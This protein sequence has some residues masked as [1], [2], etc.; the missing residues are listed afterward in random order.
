M[1]KLTKRD[2]MLLKKLQKANLYPGLQR[3]LEDNLRRY[4]AEGIN[5]DKNLHKIMPQREQQDRNDIQRPPQQLNSD[6]IG[7]R[8]ETPAGFW[9]WAEVA[10]AAAEPIAKAGVKATGNVIRRAAN[11]FYYGPKG[12]KEIL[13]KMAKN[14]ENGM[15][16]EEAEAIKDKEID[17]FWNGTE[18]A[19]ELFPSELPE[20]LAFRR[21]FREDTLPHFMRGLERS[22]RT[23]QTVLG[24]INKIIGQLQYGSNKIGKGLGKT[25][26]NLNELIG[27]GLDTGSNI[28]RNDINS[29]IGS[30]LRG[31]SNRLGQGYESLKNK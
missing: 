19:Y 17:E 28:N 30:S 3:K 18:D 21:K 6:D 4:G 23:P 22:Q 27:L 12:E 29:F 31:G 13:A 16:K 2:I 8:E 11:N 10:T 14:I 1:A 7:Q 26:R 24:D 5:V 20:D 25:G 9:P 15:S